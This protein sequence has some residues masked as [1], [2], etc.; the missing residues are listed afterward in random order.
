MRLL[1]P[2]A[3]EDLRDVPRPAR[4]G[5]ASGAEVW[6][7]RHPEVEETAAGFAYGNQDVPLSESGRACSVELARTFASREI[8]RVTSSPL[9]RALLLGRAIAEAS[10]AELVIDERLAELWRGAWQ[11]IP[12]DVYR[13]RWR[14][15]AAHYWSDPWHWK[16]NGGESDE[17]LQARTWPA[18][19]EAC[20]G[21]GTFVIT[22][23]YQVLRSIVSAALGLAPARSHALQNDPG[24]ATLLV[25]GPLGWSLARSNVRWPLGPR[26]IDP[27]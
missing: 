11:G 9:A 26:G 1:P 13:A 16:G 15:E 24:H 5:R 6:L 2:A 23:H 22:T 19:E 12:L 21:A 25:D 4:P 3:P 20:A 7:I 8:A 18:F 17:E 27:A 14:A 10:R